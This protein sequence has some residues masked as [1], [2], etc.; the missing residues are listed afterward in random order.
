MQYK[1]APH[2]TAH[3]EMITLNIN[4]TTTF[5]RYPNCNHSIGPGVQ[6]RDSVVK[7]CEALAEDLSSVYSTHIL[8]SNQI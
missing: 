8:V 7:T 1:N 3:R 5:L 6:Q 2:Y 4:T